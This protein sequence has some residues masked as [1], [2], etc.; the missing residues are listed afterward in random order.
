M[1]LTE[2]DGSQ[3]INLALQSGDSKQVKAALL[4]TVT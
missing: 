3:V 4:Q 2:S 1:R